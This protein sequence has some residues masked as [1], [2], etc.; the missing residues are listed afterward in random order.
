VQELRHEAGAGRDFESLLEQFSQQ[1]D[2]GGIHECHFREVK[3]RWVRLGTDGVADGHHFLDPRGEEFTFEFDR[4]AWA[5]GVGTTDTEQGFPIANRVCQPAK[6]RLCQKPILLEIESEC[7]A[8][9]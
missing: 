9:K 6:R 8:E 5:V 4:L 2:P 1:T 7:L 3:P